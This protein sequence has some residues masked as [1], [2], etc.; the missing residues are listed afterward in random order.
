MGSPV[1]KFHSAKLGQLLL[2]LLRN[3]ERSRDRFLNR[4]V[5][6]K[7]FKALGC[8]P[9]LATARHSNPLTGRW[10]VSCYFL[11]VVFL[12]PCPLLS[13]DC[14]FQIVPNCFCFCA[15]VL[16]P[17]GSGYLLG[18]VG[19][20]MAPNTSVA[21]LYLERL[22]HTF[23]GRIESPPLHVNSVAPAVFCATDWPGSAAV[24]VLLP[25]LSTLG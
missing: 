22:T 16:R 10:P 6:H 1:L 8:T 13:K 4:P 12:C 18:R 11:S 25:A 7:C 17:G 19:D 21:G 9:C 14:Y 20:C 5:S 3:Q 24:F 15:F 23:S 2:N